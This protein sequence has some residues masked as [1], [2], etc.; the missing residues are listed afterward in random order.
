M[1]TTIVVFIVHRVRRCCLI[2]QEG[3]KKK[4][5]DPH[6]RT[7]GTRGYLSTRSR[8]LALEDI[9]TRKGAHAGKRAQYLR[10]KCMMSVLWKRKHAVAD[11]GLLLS[12]WIW[13]HCAQWT[14]FWTLFRLAFIYSFC[15]KPLT[16]YCALPLCFWGHSTPLN[17]TKRLR[18]NTNLLTNLQN[19]YLVAK[20][21]GD[22]EQYVLSHIC[23]ELLTWH[24]EDRENKAHGCMGS[25]FNQNITLKDTLV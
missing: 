6:R 9:W 15:E 5:V 20:V 10:V 11:T 23:I 12:T 22:I 21:S 8:P 16:L 2:N 14:Y 25:W 4:R 18:R 19:I 17:K 7:R 3:K 1:I 24:L 13:Q